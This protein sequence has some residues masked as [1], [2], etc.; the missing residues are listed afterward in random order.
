[1]TRLAAIYVLELIDFI[2]RR[3]LRPRDAIQILRNHEKG[4]A[5]CKCSVIAILESELEHRIVGA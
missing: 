2:I 3:D 5:G 1:M 4:C